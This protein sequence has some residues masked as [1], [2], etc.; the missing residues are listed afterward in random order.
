MSFRR[1]IAGSALAQRLVRLLG[2]VWKA[3]NRRD[4]LLA[5]GPIM[6]REASAADSAQRFRAGDACEHLDEGPAF[7]HKSAL[8]T[9]RV[10]RPPSK[11]LERS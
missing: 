6:R 3:A 5:Q 4:C 1:G 9:A 2:F 11:T 8:R 10:R 7:L